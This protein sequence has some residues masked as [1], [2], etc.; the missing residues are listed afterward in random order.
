MFVTDL[1]CAGR[2]ALGCLPW[3]AQSAGSAM[4]GAPYDLSVHPNDDLP[5]EDIMLLDCSHSHSSSP[6]LPSPTAAA[7]ADDD[8]LLNTCKETPLFGEFSLCLS[9][10]CL[11]KMI[12]FSCK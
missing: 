4:L 3:A 12:I 11:G 10:A 1:L 9:R 2:G 7:S 8:A 6:R 5:E